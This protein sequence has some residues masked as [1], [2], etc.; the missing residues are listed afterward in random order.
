[1]EVLSGEGIPIGFIDEAQY[2]ERQIALMPGDRIFVYSDGI[3]EAKDNTPQEFGEERLMRIVSDLQPEGLADSLEGLT[4]EVESWCGSAGVK[5]DLS[6]L[7]LEV[8]TTA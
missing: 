2:E 6:L 7:G 3:T 1:V 4:R 8:L 5:D